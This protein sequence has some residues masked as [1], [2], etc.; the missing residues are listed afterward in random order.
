[1]TDEEFLGEQAERVLENPA[2][3]RAITAV[4]GQ[5]YQEWSETGFFQRRKRERLWLMQRVVNQFES[6]LARMVDGRKL[7][8]RMRNG[9]GTGTR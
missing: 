9:R 2:Y 4:K 5:V 7:M 1:M 3:Q 6:E 8:L